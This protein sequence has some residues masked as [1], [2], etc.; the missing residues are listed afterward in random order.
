VRVPCSQTPTGPR[1]QAV[2]TPR[3]CLPRFVPRRLPRLRFLRGSITRPTHPLSTLRRGG[4][5]NTTQDSL[6]G[7]GPTLPGR[8]LH[9]QGSNERFQLMHPP[10][11]GFAWRKRNE[12]ILAP[13]LLRLCITD[14]TT[15]HYGQSHAAQESLDQHT[16][17][18]FL[19]VK[20]KR[21]SEA[22]PMRINLPP[23]NTC[24]TVIYK[25]QMLD[26]LHLKKWRAANILPVQTNLGGSGEPWPIP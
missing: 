12:A 5:P 2:T 14:Y 26:H 22:E 6:P 10:F 25:S 20:S 13:A 23:V 19:R 18:N 9:P 3:C 8:D 15:G 24:R 11:P 21:R 7:G 1:R 16:H 4:R 17:A